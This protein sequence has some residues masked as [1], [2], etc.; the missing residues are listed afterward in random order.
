VTSST[1]SS[2]TMRIFSP[3]ILCAVLSACGGGGSSSPAA[4]TPA[5]STPVSPAPPPV[6]AAT[7]SL[8]S[9]TLRTIAG[10]SAIPMTAK[11]SSGGAVH[12]QLA[13]GA[14]GS[15]STDSGTT[16]RYQPPAGPLAAATT[17][18]VT[19]SGDGAS[20]ALTLAL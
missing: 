7:L 8:S 20:A 6:P 17:V 11:L 10:G 18:T 9:P 13:A 3:L 2:D 5:P 1:I 14:P 4:S 15:L 19:A 12:W 16:V